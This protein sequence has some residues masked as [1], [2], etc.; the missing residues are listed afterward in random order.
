L[1]DFWTPYV[2]YKH[3]IQSIRYATISASKNPAKKARKTAF[4][5][6]LGLD[7]LGG[8]HGLDRTLSDF[9]G[10]VVSTIASKRVRSRVRRLC[11]QYLISPEGRRLSMERGEIRRILKLDAGT[12]DELVRGRLLRSDQRA[13]SWYYELSHDS[14]VAPILATRKRWGVASGLAGLLASSLVGLFGLAIA[15]AGLVEIGRLILAP[16]SLLRPEGK[17]PPGFDEEGY[18]AAMFLGFTVGSLFFSAFAALSLW[19]GGRGI[20]TS[21]ETLNRFLSP[22]T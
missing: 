14:L 17:L 2:W 1:R 3:L 21:V 16:E 20:R 13:E 11:E 15:V 7:D 18:A 4:L 12:L 9:Y 8:E 22:P 10:N 6:T 5:D 19:V